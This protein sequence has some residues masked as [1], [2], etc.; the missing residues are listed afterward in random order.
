MP[1]GGAG[2]GAANL[3]W[4]GGHDHDS[5]SQGMQETSRLR[6]GA[7]KD[8]TQANA[9]KHR[10]K[11]SYKFSTHMLCR[12]YGGTRSLVLVEPILPTYIQ[13]DLTLDDP[14]PL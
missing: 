7:L 2:D 12:R 3:W 4:L 9:S 8:P 11:G 1:G 6:P 13:A 10:G 5:L 14:Q